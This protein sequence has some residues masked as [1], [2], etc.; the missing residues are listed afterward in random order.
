MDIPPRRKL[1]HSGPN[2]YQSPDDRVNGRL[3]ALAP[4]LRIADHMERI[5]RNTSGEKPCL[6]GCGW[7]DAY[8][9]S[10][11]EPP[12]PMPDGMVDAFNFTRQRPIPFSGGSGKP[13]S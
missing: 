6:I 3:D 2:L 13:S 10:V 11:L 7:R 1:D 5:I 4:E 12:P 8:G 9:D